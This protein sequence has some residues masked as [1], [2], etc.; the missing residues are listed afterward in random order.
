[1]KKSSIFRIT[2]FLLATTVILF[3]CKDKKTTGESTKI[4]FDSIVVEKQIPLL[5][6]N[7]TTL[8]YADVKVSFTYPTR[9]R[10]DEDLARLQQIFLGT[11]FDDVAY[12]S[13]SPANAADKYIADYTTEYKKLSNDFYEEKNR[14]E[15]K[16]PQW[17]WYYM[18]NTN[19]ILHQ[20]DSIISY[21]V[22][23]A[24][25]TGG[26]HGSYRVTYTNVDLNELVTLSEE[27]IFIPDYYNPLTEKIVNR[28]MKDHDVTEPDSLLRRGFF[29]VEDIMPNNNFWLN[30]EGIHYAYNQYEIAPYSSGV[31]EVTIPYSDLKDILLPG[32]IVSRYF[33][34]EEIEK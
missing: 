4:T 20:N 18:Y 16:T 3:S 1:M 23:Y 26:A 25:Y 31:I 33:L 22:E 5:V 28:L 6:E 9:F 8:P 7:D 27:D 11:F 24:D 34:K 21:A 14:L 10:N 15:G 12:D 30:E 32:G 2:A 19:K 29:A 17:Y 13:L